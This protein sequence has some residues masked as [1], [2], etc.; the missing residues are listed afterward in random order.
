[1]ASFSWVG[2]GQRR[3]IWL[4]FLSWLQ[5]MKKRKMTRAAVEGESHL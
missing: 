5:I 3:K 1:M 4:Q 2:S